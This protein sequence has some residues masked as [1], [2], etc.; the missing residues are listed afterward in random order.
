MGGDK[1]ISNFT[2]PPL[3][4]PALP[5]IQHTPVFIH[6]NLSD[7]ILIPCRA[8]GIPHPTVIWYR[9]GEVVSTEGRVRHL[10]NGSLLI[11]NTTFDDDGHYHCVAS[12]KAGQ[13]SLNVSLFSVLERETPVNDLALTSCA[14]LIAELIG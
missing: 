12:N 14:A 6:Y 10:R 3:T 1:R 8:R 5:A 9:K 4:S 13:D 2:P 11:S 7:T